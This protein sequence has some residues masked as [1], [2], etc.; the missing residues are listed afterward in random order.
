LKN[1][2]LITRENSE[3]V[4]HVMVYLCGSYQEAKQFCRFINSISLE[5]GERFNAREIYLNREYS[6]EKYVPFTFDDILTISNRNLQ[7]LL[8]ELD[9]DILVLA[10]KDAKK[11]IKDHF[12]KNM[13]KRASGML[14]EDIEYVEPYAESDIEDARQL[15]LDTYKYLSTETFD[16]AIDAFGKRTKIKL[17]KCFPPF[18]EE[19]RNNIVM[20][21]RGSGNIADSVSISIY[22]T[23]HLADGLCNYLNELETEKGRFIYARHIKPMV[24]YE[25]TKPLLIRF[26]QILE[27]NGKIHNEHCNILIIKEALKNFGTYTLLK[28]FKGIDKRSREIIMQCLSIKTADEINDLIENNHKYEKYTLSETRQARQKIMDAINRNAIKFE[29]GDFH[30]GVFLKD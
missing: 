5:C 26:E 13:S 14:K 18:A 1:I 11:E 16:K 25:I 22:E 6:L 19:E 12:F 23:Y 20:V 27:H 2:V 4:T 29:R 30:K 21:F 9:S 3:K 8:R 24:E 28:A 7:K 17:R 15:I 10:L